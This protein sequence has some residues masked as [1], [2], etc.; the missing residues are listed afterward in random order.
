MLKRKYD[1]LQSKVKV[2]Q[3]EDQVHLEKNLSSKIH[4][5]ANKGETNTQSQKL[6]DRIKSPSTREAKK[7]KS[8]KPPPFKAGGTYVSKEKVKYMSPQERKRA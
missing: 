8:D 1:S 7:G 3:D 4:K 2:W 6:I 5:A